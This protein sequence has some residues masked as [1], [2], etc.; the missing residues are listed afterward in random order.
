MCKT[1]RTYNN[2]QT[3]NLI[4]PGIYWSNDKLNNYNN[5]R[6]ST[7]KKTLVAGQFSNAFQMLIFNFTWPFNFNI[8]SFMGC[9]ENVKLLWKYMLDNLIL[10]LKETIYFCYVVQPKFSIHN[11]S[12]TL[13]NIIV[14]L[15][16]ITVSRSEC[17]INI[18]RI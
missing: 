6:F 5:A 12:K 8:I 9:W 16:F 17:I 13:E 14:F 18:L 2:E 3:N 11:S 4:T 1:T 7:S 15:L 10:L